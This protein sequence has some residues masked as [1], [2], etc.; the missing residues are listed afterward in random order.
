MSRHQDKRGILI[1]LPERDDGRGPHFHGGIKIAGKRYDLTGWHGK[2]RYGGPLIVL[3][4]KPFSAPHDAE[5]TNETSR[6]SGGKD[7]AQ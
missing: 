4:V 5:R 3:N 6:K 2:S 1:P 7:G